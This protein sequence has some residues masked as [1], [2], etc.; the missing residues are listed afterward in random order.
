MGGNRF[1]R[2]R[3]SQEL[4]CS[5]VL[6]SPLLSFHD[7]ER[8]AWRQPEGENTEVVVRRL[9]FSKTTTLGN[10]NSD[11]L[12][13]SRSSVTPE[14]Y[15]LALS[16]ASWHP[17]P[18]RRIHPAFRLAS[19]PALVRR[20]F[21]LSSSGGEGWGEVALSP[22]SEGRKKAE[23]RNPKGCIKLLRFMRRGWDLIAYSQSNPE[24]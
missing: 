6:F 2:R 22:K 23:F 5:R 3:H 15:K 17:P 11:I 1:Y 7:T 21:P 24:G 13:R 14:A 18:E 10:W 9:D 8:R 12:V 19:P 20:C 16:G 4:G